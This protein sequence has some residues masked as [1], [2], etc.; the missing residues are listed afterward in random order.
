MS[1]LERFGLAHPIVQAGM[2]GGI[3]GGRLA[4]AVSGAG[5]LGTVGI[6][7]P[8][9]MAAELALARE[10]ANGGSATATGGS[11]K[12]ATAGPP[13]AANLL[14][15]FTRREHVDTCR[16]AS[17]P[18]V[19]LH[20][21]FDRQLVVA[22]RDSQI[23]VFQTV[24][25]PDQARWAIAEGADGLVVQGREAGGHLVGVEPA[26]TALARIRDAMAAMDVSSAPN[27]PLLLAGGIADAADVKRGLAAGADAVV[28]G[29]RFLLTDESGAH[30]EYK[31]RVLEAQRTIETYLFGLGWPMRHRVVPN[32]AT[33]RWCRGDDAGPALL[34]AAYRLSAP[35]GRLPLSATGRL[36]NFQRPAIPLFGPSGSVEGMP[37]RLIEATALYAGDTALR[38]DS[39]LP[40]AEAV[41]LLTASSAASATE[42]P[43][44]EAS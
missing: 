40:A 15:P 27:K 3:A 39:I 18:I 19:V 24:G 33:D 30:P 13:V 16:R 44:I 1:F 6:L 14:V 9:I 23:F 7:P 5:G 20:G 10:V 41:A 29:T 26:L 12:A 35:L 32:A 34:R 8:E 22:L 17:T 42:S 28:A 25:T 36:V 4:G 43:T 31:R 2:G 11:G 21:G 37:D 38:I